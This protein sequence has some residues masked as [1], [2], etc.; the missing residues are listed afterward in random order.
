LKCKYYWQ[1]TPNGQ[2]KVATVAIMNICFTDDH[3]YVPFVKVTSTT[4]L[5]LSLLSSSDY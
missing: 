3:E 1:Y 2:V 4:F 5:Q